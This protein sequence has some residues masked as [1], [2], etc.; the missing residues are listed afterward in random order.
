MP[1]LIFF[2]IHN[3]TQW[4]KYL[5]SQIDFAD[6]T[7]LS[8]LR[9]DGDRS[10]IDDFY[11]F[12]RKGD[13]AETAV[14]R[15]GEEGC[16]EIILRCRVLRSLD[17]GLA[18]RMIGGMAQAIERAFDDLDPDLVVTFTMDR[19]VFDVMERIARARG[20]DFLEMTTSI[21]PDEVMLM[22]RGKPVRLREPSESEVEAAVRLLCE[23]DF[24]P[25][26]VRNARKFSMLRFW[27]VFGYFALRGAYFNVLRFLQ[28]DRFNL[29]YLDAL[30]RLKHKV[31]VSDVAALSLLDRKW[32]ARLDE[33]PRQRRAFLALQLFP[34]ASMDYWLKS[35]DMLAHD[36]VIVRYCEVLGEAGYRTFV[37]DHPLQ[38]GFRQIELL[39][40]LAKLPFVTLVP[41]EVPANFMLD[42]CAISISFTGTVGF[43]AALSG[44]CSVVTEPYYATERHFIHVRSFDEIGSLVERLKQWW[45]AGELGEVR[46]DIVRHM[47]AISVAGNYFTWHRFDPEKPGAREAA[48]SL[49][50]SLNQYLPRFLKSRKTAA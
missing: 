39:E 23:S 13:A 7:V 46:R 49:V 5:G 27:R 1:R 18:L 35:H 11:R 38:F 31:R 16:A 9:A 10:L 29:H 17:R 36:D 3:T 40:R 8:D 33:V 42:K 4:W 44:L 47:A 2:T 24:V 45:P 6:V 37:K 50:R 30:K 41:Y 19:Y 26:Y 12:M 43:Q 25:A 34:E 32:E 48:E 21:I 22:R 28:R 15:F 14:A 20:I